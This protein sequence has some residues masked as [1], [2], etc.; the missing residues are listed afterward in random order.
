MSPYY[1]A[2]LLLFGEYTVLSG[3]QALAVPLNQWSGRWEQHEHQNVPENESLTRYVDWLQSKDII[4]PSKAA[5][6]IEEARLG[7]Q[8]VADIPIGFGLGSS[9]AYVAAIYD[10]YVAG[11]AEATTGKTHALLRNM[12]GFFHGSS[13]GMD[14][15]VSYTHQAL[16]R[17]EQGDLHPINDPGWP[18]GY[19]IFLLDTGVARTT[20]ALVSA[21]RKMLE[22][23]QFI[24]SIERELIPVVE[25]AIHF[26]L[27]RSGSKLEEC[28]S[29]ISDFQR[30]YL[31][32]FIPVSTQK[33]WNDL[34]ENQGMYIK[35][36]GAGGGGYFLLIT[37]PT[38]SGE[39]PVNAIPIRRQS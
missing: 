33:Q 14:P 13:S 25:H 22:V 35:F 2:K 31:S 11:A 18:D 29:L 24:L 34:R 39:L 5:E 1:P 4:K 15:L 19:N 23:E 6:I 30:T 9:G 27:S 12:E 38:F 20:S 3:S 17:S 21:Y 37:A 16:Y 7:W 28:L 26:Y 8:Y 10:R 36:C 32:D